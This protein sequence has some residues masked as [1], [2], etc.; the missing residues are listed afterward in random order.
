MIAPAVGATALGFLAIAAAASEVRGLFGSGISP[1]ALLVLGLLVASYVRGLQRPRMI[2][3]RAGPVQHG[4]F[5]AGILALALSFDAPLAPLGERLF[6]LHQVQHLALRMIGPMLIVLA[7]PGPVMRAGFP[8]LWRRWLRGPRPAL[9]GSAAFVARLPVAWVLLVAALYVW[10]VPA[11]H[12]AVV[13]RPALATF[14]HLT[15]TAAGAVFFARVLDRR[16]PPAGPP[17]GARVLALVALVLSN[18][19]LGSL[20]TLKERVLYTAYDSAGRLYGLS[21]LADETIGG[22]TIWVPS[23]MVVI[24]AMLVVFNGWHRSEEQVWQRRLEW[25]GSNS[26]ALEFPQTAAELRLKVAE[27][28]VRTGRTLALSAATMLLLVLATAITVATWG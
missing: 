24:A 4:L 27:R 15:M 23:S 9:A 28:N 18:I 20:T 5:A 19:L 26:A 12:N 16:S 6:A 3:E 2:G 13:A 17:Q 1:V 22:Y 21:P 11:V 7:Y 10:Q 25:T 14:A 8:R